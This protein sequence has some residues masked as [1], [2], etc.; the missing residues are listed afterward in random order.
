MNLPLICQLPQPTA[1]ARPVFPKAAKVKPAKTNRPRAAR[2]KADPK[3]KAKAKA[4]PKAGA[5]RAEEDAAPSR[6][7]RSRQD[8]K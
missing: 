1:H 7:K 6:S 2:A 5:K 3:A 4:S 8:K